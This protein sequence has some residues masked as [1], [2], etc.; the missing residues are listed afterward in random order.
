MKPMVSKCGVANALAA[1]ALVA[2]VAAWPQI[3][4]AVDVGKA[5]EPQQGDVQS[6]D[7]NEQSKDIN[8]RLWDA[9][10]SGDE[11]LVKQLLEQGA[12]GGATVNK[13]RIQI[14]SFAI[15]MKDGKWSGGSVGYTFRPNTP[16][17][18]AADT[19][20][21][22]MIRLLLDSG[23]EDKDDAAF[24]HAVKKGH[25]DVVRDFLVARSD[26]GND[27][28]GT[29]VCGEV[30]QKQYRGALGERLVDFLLNSWNRELL[31]LFAKVGLEIDLSDLSLE[32]ANALLKKGMEKKNA[33]AVSVAL[34]NGAD[35]NV[36]FKVKF[37]PTPALVLAAAEGW[38]DVATALLDGGADPNAKRSDDEGAT[39]LIWA[40]Y[41]DH[42]E[43]VKLLLEAGA[44]VNATDNQGDT[45]VD[46]ARRR[47]NAQVVAILEE[48][49]QAAG[50]AGSSH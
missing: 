41:G 35:A 42:A 21:S 4:Q 27:W 34:A 16:L 1:I 31:S 43:I 18:K 20:A 38:R 8:V 49:A 30:C 14:D 24:V 39:A 10:S 45:A 19:S 46:E 23:A 13:G 11:D 22:A 47:G 2:V 17:K 5:P 37:V 25:V 40:A 28:E 50:T 29:I 7:D 33:D 48:A 26:N 9:V 36:E 12:N 32:Q 6:T 3:V 44:D 15:S